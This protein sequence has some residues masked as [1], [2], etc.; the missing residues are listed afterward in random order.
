[1]HRISR[2]HARLEND[3]AE[4]DD[5]V[6]QTFAALDA[7]DAAKIFENLDFFWA[8]LGMHIR[9]EHLRLFPAVREIAARSQE[10]AA[11]PKILDQLREDHDFFM[12]ELAR[13]IKAM[14]LV[15]SFG[16]ETET[17]AVVRSIL[18]A[19]VE[20]LKEH[21]DIEEEQIYTLTTDE[22]LD[23]DSAVQLL[24]TVQMELDRYPAR[25]ESRSKQ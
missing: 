17:F 2:I 12:T 23:D 1:M 11:I 4:L 24:A 6:A 14:R 25:F 15:F 10:L 7:A 13:A 16:N 20:R 3:H 22:F 8:R 21:N 19:V 5:L 18:E 9:A